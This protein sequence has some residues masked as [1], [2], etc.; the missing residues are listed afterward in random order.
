VAGTDY[1]Q[2]DA[3]FL[4]DISIDGSTL[5]VTNPGPAPHPGDSFIIICNDGPDPVTGAFAGL[6][7]GAAVAV[8]SNLLHIT[9]HGGDGNDVALVAPTADLALTLTASPAAVTEGGT[10]TYTLTV[11]NNGPATAA[12]VTLSDAVPA[13]AAFVSSGFAGYDAATGQVNLGTLAAGGSVTGTLVVRVPEEGTVVNTARVSSDLPDPNPADN[14]QTLTTTVADFVPVVSLGG[15]A[16]L[17]TGQPLSRL[18]SFL[19]PSGDTW[20]GVVSY[21]D[22]SAAAL[23]LNPDHSFALSHLYAQ[24]GNYTVTVKISDGH[25][26]G[27]GTLTVHVLPPA[28]VQ[29]VVVNDGSAQ[30]S[31]VTS[32][33]VT[34]STQVDLAPG[35]FTLV[36][37]Y[38]GTTT[39]VSGLLQVST[40]LVNGRTVAT[41]TFAGAGITGG[42]L[43]DG[44]YTLT[45]HSNLVTDHQ[46]GAALDGDGNGLA[47]GDRVDH[48]FRLFGDATGDGKVDNADQAAFLAAYRSRKGMANYAWYFDANGDSL[49]DSTD[50]YQFLRRN[51]TAI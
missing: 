50:Y 14:G 29:S 18:G 12:N 21:G 22:G 32:V 41:L 33:T 39:D 25:V 9:Y 43:A 34:F 7:E 35:A 11:T 3:G 51:G 38:A 26:T 46:L 48:F 47:G 40:A 45:I 10:I 16:S 49:I 42:S 37:A 15:A 19:D 13:G 44:R 6:P 5:H 28:S 30:R 4:G 36:Q 23:S 17:R 20:R 24:A 31:L 8:G 1:D 2:V 27:L